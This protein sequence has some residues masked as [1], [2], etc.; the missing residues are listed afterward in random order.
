MSTMTHKIKI[1]RKN[2][3]KVAGHNETSEL[4]LDRV[5]SSVPHG[6]VFPNASSNLTNQ[7]AFG[8]T[9]QSNNADVLA[10]KSRD[11]IDLSECVSF[12]PNLK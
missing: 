9:Q 8:D 12:Q 2:E 11:D 4:D 5:D 3:E 7:L 1:G 10:K 6:D